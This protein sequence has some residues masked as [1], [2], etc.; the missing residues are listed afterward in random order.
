MSDLDVSERN[1]RTQRRPCEYVRAHFAPDFQSS[2]ANTILDATIFTELRNTHPTE[3]PTHRTNAP[4]LCPIRH[5]GPPGTRHYVRT[6]LSLPS[7]APPLK[8]WRTK[9]TYVA[10]PRE[11]PPT[12][13]QLKTAAFNVRTPRLREYVR[14]R[15]LSFASIVGAIVRVLRHA[16]A[17]CRATT[18]PQPKKRY[19]TPRHLVMDVM[20]CRRGS[21]DTLRCE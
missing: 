6:R 19:R 10:W 9:V 11:T 13:R 3:L 1:D 21:S 17:K 15:T 18:Q 2:N 8:D 4:A 16:A 7:A 5:T 14:A 12:I 20:G